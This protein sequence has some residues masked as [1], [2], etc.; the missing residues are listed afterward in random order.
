M[1]DGASRLPAVWFRFNWFLGSNCAFG[2][3]TFVG[4]CQ[5]VAAVPRR[6]YFAISSFRMTASWPC[7]ET[8]V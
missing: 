4:Q 6:C 2:R 7:P 5:E 8:A 3:T 1:L